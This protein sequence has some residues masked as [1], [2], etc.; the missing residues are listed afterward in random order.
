VLTASDA[1][2]RWTLTDDTGRFRLD[3]LDPATYVL[4][5]RKAGFGEYR[6]SLVI[7][8]AADVTVDITLGIGP[9][10]ESVT[11]TALRGMAQDI[12]ASPQVVTVTSALELSRREL[13]VFTRALIGEPGVHV[14]QT[15]TSQGSP[16]IRGLTG[17]QVVTLVDGVRF[18]NAT[19]RP[20]ANQYSALL[21]PAFVDRVEIVRARTDP[22]TDRIRS[23]HH[24]RPDEPARRSPGSIRCGR[25]PHAD[26]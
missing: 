8:D 16:F 4:A 25:R 26:R 17:Q 3:A 23:R 24:Q 22:S 12:Q 21:D 1:E 18:N 5:V 7:G 14:Q 13:A 11:V 9:V 15:S 20:G 6:R 19:F 2:V 10:N